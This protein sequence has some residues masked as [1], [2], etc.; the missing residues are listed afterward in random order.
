MPTPGQN[1]HP[2]P[3]AVSPADSVS[4]P[5]GSCPGHATAP[6][7]RWRLLRMSTTGE[8]SWAD[9][10]H[11]RRHHHRHRR[12]PRGR[13]RASI[14]QSHRDPA[15]QAVRLGCQS[16]CESARK[17]GRPWPTWTGSC[18]NRPCQAADLSQARHSAK[19]CKSGEGLRDS[20]GGIGRLWVAVPPAP[21]RAAGA[22][23]SVPACEG[24][25]GHPIPSQHKRV[26]AGSES[27]TRWR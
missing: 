11:R 18:Q 16:S 23:G 1:P 21:V 4:G 9:R 2:P 8:H 12:D 20:R 19:P 27:R 14:R 17:R 24:T 22:V 3:P 15:R 13:R 25:H 7:R 10:R 26:R 5:A 6:Y